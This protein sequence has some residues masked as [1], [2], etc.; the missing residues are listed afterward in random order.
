[1]LLALCF[2]WFLL[3][4]RE[5]MGDFQ[6]WLLGLGL[7]GVGLFALMVVVMTFLPAPDWPLPV[8]AG[9]VY[10]VW[11]FPLVFATTAFAACLVFLVARYLAR[12]RVRAVLQR[13]P[14]YKAI[15]KA[16]A[17]EGW[18]VVVLLRLSPFVPFNLQNYAF[19]VT[20]IPFTE[21]LWA[22]LVGMLPGVVIYV[23]FGMFGKRLGGPHDPLEWALLGFGILASVVLAV[24]VTRKTKEKFAEA[25]DP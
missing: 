15:D 9:F 2:G 22:T 8:V 12:D 19:G 6:H 3:P 17:E 14:K 25:R 5:W 7:W 4:L 18:R 21:Y 16:V 20:A 23:Y 11:A 13:Q 10:G 1:M 24:L